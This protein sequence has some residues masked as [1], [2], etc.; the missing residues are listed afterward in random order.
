LASNPHSVNLV[1]RIDWGDMDLYGHINN[2][3][4]MRYVQAGR[5]AFWENLGLASKPEESGFGFVLASTHCDFKAS[6]FYPGSVKIIT[7]LDFIKNSSIGLK[8][9]VFN[10]AGEIAAETKDVLVTYDY[11]DR[12]KINIPD[13]VREKFEKE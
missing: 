12:K 8:H 2:V 13:W 9:I 5:I 1:L 11:I 4:F 3:A 7:E 6:L 10:D